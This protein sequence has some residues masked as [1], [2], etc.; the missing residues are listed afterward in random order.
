[1]AGISK[2]TFFRWLRSGSFKD[3]SNIDRRGWCMFTTDDLRRLKAEVKQIRII[4][5]GQSIE[6]MPAHN[7]R[8][9]S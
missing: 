6:P 1:M 3:V 8:V 2:S 9:R 7:Y 4:G 5:D